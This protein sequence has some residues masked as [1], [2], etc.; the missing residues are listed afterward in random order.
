MLWHH[1]QWD[2][3]LKVQSSDNS[4]IV[5][6]SSVQHNK[7]GPMLATRLAKSLTIHVSHNAQYAVDCSSSSNIHP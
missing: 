2:P 7:Q 3:I 1:E 4:G 5:G 6:K